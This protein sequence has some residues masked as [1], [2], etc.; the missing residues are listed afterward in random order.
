M[1][2]TVL[3][4]AALLKEG[5][6]GAD[7]TLLELKTEMILVKTFLSAPIAPRLDL[8]LL[9]RLLRVFETLAGDTLCGFVAMWFVR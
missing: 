6:C 2:V 4:R 9:E 1:T 8:V 3:S 5:R 7:E